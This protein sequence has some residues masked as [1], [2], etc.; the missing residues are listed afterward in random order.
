MLLEKEILNLSTFTFSAHD[1]AFKSER[2]RSHGD[3]LYY[4]D[5]Q[6]AACFTIN[7]LEQLEE[8]WSIQLSEDEYSGFSIL[9]V[10]DKHV[11]ITSDAADRV[12]LDVYD[13]QTDKL[14]SSVLEVEERLASDGSR[15]TPYSLPK[16]IA[17]LA[18]N[19]LVYT[20]P[21]DYYN[22]YRNEVVFFHI[23]AKKK[24]G[25]LDLASC[26]QTRPLAW[27]RVL[28]SIVP[29]ELKLEI[30]EIILEDIQLVD[31][32]LTVLLSSGHMLGSNRPGSYQLIQF[33]PSAAA[34]PSL[35][36]RTWSTATSL[37]QFF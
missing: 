12:K 2:F 28:A 23:L 34:Q 8:K 5:D 22:Q 20:K 10:N 4:I 9:D 36:Q 31:R 29:A 37:F 17:H 35:L 13:S 14:I 16:S 24:I 19:I 33:A 15:F 25:E 18:G 32:K 30:P 27:A 3:A 7:S 21:V 6:R 11:L 26:L 1:F